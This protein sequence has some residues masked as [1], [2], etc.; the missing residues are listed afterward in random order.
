MSLID[1]LIRQL[2][3]QG[4][5]F[6]PLRNV[7]K[8]VPGLSGK[9]K[10]DFS[11]GN[12][13]FVSYKNAFAHIA[14]D[15]EAPDFVNVGPIEKQ[16]RLHE[17]DVV[18]TGSSEST[19][20]V[21]MS[22]VVVAEPSEPLYLNSFCFAVRFDK[23]ELLLPHFSK[24]LFRGDSI[25]SQIR[26]SASGVTRFNVSKD[27]FM[28]TR[29]P[30]PP[31]EVQREIVRILDTFTAL[32]AELETELEARRH[33]YE[34][35]RDRLLTPDHRAEWNSLGNLLANRDSRRRPVTR[36]QRRSGV[37]PYYGANGVQ[38][39]VD[40]FIFDGTFLLMGEDGSVTQRD[41]SPILNWAS[42]K[43]WVNNH[44][45]VLISRT[46]ATNLRYVYYYLQTVD[47]GAFVTGGT[48]PKLNQGNLNRIP[49]P[50]VPREQQDEIVE[51]LD[52]FDALVNDLS[53]GLPAELAARRRQYEFY[54]DRLLTFEEAAS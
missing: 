39:Y 49:L 25:H 13:R 16:N 11:G 42:G 17:G 6:V 31:L 40:G 3:P 5:Q 20:E 48:Q 26:R 19:D 24:Y 27:R 43:I 47:I 33:Q 9:S 18:F 34:H 45:H 8:T 32:E 4:V 23:P 30:V 41:G 53:I 14:V 38:D 12:A 52:Q 22:S 44:A 10:A 7:A 50:V 46:A 2:S 51:A 35:Y 29:I 37:Y 28:K 1:D 21:G 15:Q 36:A 54:R